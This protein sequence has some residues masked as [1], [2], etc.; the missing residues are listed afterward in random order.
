ML[1]WTWELVPELDLSSW[2]WPPT[3]SKIRIVDKKLQLLT[4]TPNRPWAIFWA[5]LGVPRTPYPWF[6]TAVTF[7]PLHGFCWELETE[8][9]SIENFRVPT[10]RSI[11]W[12][13]QKLRPKWRNWLN[14]LR[15]KC[16][17]SVNGPNMAK[18]S[19]YSQLWTPVTFYPLDGFC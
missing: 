11:R 3:P 5:L 15:C 16:K 17:I 8:C 7:Y 4:F 19:P 1:F 9:R 12:L 14:Y 13:D 18:Y 10:L 2:I 6:Q